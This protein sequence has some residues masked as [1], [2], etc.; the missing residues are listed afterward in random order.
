MKK[1][2]RIASQNLGI[3]AL[4]LALA[5]RFFFQLNQTVY[6]HIYFRAVFPF[7]RKVQSGIDAFWI[8]PGYY[9][10][11]SLVLAWLI[12][13]WPNRKGIKKFSL[14][15]G[16]L[17]SG[18]AAIFLFLFGYMYL[19]RGYV[20]RNA[21]TSVPDK[22]NLASHYL[23]TMERAVE[24]RVAL[25]PAADTTKITAIS[26]I[27][28]AGEIQK[29]VGNVLS[30]Y[31]AKRTPIKNV[32]FKPKGVLRRLGISG[33]YNPFTG[34]TNVD[35]AL[36]NIQNVFV[37]AHEMA[38]AIG[39][40]SEAEADFVAYLACLQSGDA[41][42]EYAAEYML[43]RQIAR[44]INKTYPKEVIEQL[45]MNIPPQLQ[46]DRTALLA[47]YFAHN[48]YFP[49]VTKSLNNTYLKVQGIE[50]GADDYDGFLKIY[51]SWNQKQIQVGNLSE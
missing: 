27:P 28:E 17:L 35:A 20:N 19:D 4:V 44:E 24:L 10:L 23:A 14:R 40:T 3:S 49:G 1:L 5:M 29:W 42:A 32:Q 48:A 15:L 36:P 33:I 18:T 41:L 30:D 37:S 7:I 21:L 47:S 46:R 45:A 25:I 43:W 39:I 51:L 13:R 8:V 9:I 26:T 2:K 31:P 50:A 16:N 6:E 22:V 12:W 34:E 11:C 38:H